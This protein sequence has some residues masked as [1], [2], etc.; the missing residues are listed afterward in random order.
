MANTKKKSRPAKEKEETMEKDDKKIRLISY[1]PPSDLESFLSE[2]SSDM[3]KPQKVITFLLRYMLM[4]YS[5][6]DIDQILVKFMTGKSESFKKTSL[7]NTG[8]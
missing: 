8:T 5:D 6:A 3:V 1:R 4:T 7:K 2:K